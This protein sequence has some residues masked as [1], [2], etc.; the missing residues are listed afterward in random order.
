MSEFDFLLAQYTKKGNPKVHGVLAKC[1]DKNGNEIYSK[2][3]GYDSL[4]IDASPLREDAVFKLASATKLMTSIALLQCVDRG[5]IDLDE[6]LSKIIPELD[7]KEVLTAGPGTDFTSEPSKHKI[8]A[9]H[10]LTHT[11][12]L[13]YRLVQFVQPALMAWT[14]TPAGQEHKNKNSKVVTEKYNTPLVFEPG[15]GWAYG[16]S[17]DWAGVVVSRLHNGMSLEDYMIENIWKKVGLSS[18]FP[19]FAISRDPEYAARLMQGAERTS[20]GHLKAND[21]PYLDNPQ[22]QE[23]GSGLASTAKDYLAVL[24]D[25]ISDSPKLLKPETISEMFTPQI[26]ADSPSIPMLMQ[27]RPAWDNVSGPVSGDS[28]NHGLGGL[29]LLGDAPEIRQPKNILAWSGAPNII[30]F[31][32][33]EAGVAGFFATQVSPF[34]E[35]EARKLIYAWKKD[36]WDTFKSKL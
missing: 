6:P 29:L 19:T 15:D 12:G 7:G 24:G 31:A 25:L 10:L 35:P 30:W 16:S 32:C 4:S 17:L 13:A 34:G 5:L 11:S 27:L 21:F 8:T 28:V 3:S 33:K 9:R 1:I 20:D 26:A 36:F 14:A 22:G 23:G 2:I 18:P